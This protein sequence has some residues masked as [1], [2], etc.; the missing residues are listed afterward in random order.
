MVSRELTMRTDSHLKK[1]AV[2][3]LALTGFLFSG[4]CGNLA[5]RGI[6][7][8]FRAGLTTATSGFVLG[9]LS[10]FFEGSAPSDDTEEP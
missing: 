5:T 6:T 10:T 7:D 3:L 2:I 9:V 8:G 1:V 4:G